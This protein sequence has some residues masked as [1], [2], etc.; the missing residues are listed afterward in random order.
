MRPQHAACATAN[1]GLVQRQERVRYPAEVV[2][3]QDQAIAHTWAPWGVGLLALLVTGWDAG[4]P[5]LW[6]DEVVTLTMAERSWSSMFSVLGRIDAVHGVYYSVIHL[7][8]DVLPYT[9]FILRLPSVILVS[10]TA[11]VLFKMGAKQWNLVAGIVAGL[12]FIGIPR[13]LWM[14]TQARSY[15]LAA[16]TITLAIYLFVVALE[17]NQRRLWV[18]FGAAMALAVWA[19]L[20]NILLVP[21]LVAVALLQRPTSG[22]LRRA[23]I[24]VAAVVAAALPLILVAASQRGQIGWIN[25]TTLKRAL[26]APYYAFFDGT[27]SIMAVAGWVALVVVCGAMLG[28]LTF[29]TP[30]GG[31]EGALSPLAAFTLVLG[32]LALPG[33]VLLTAGAFMSLYYDTYLVISVPALALMIGGGIAA[34]GS[35]KWQAPA[36]LVL[37]AVLAYQPWGFFREPNSKSDIL[38]VIAL[39]ETHARPGDDILFVE[40]GDWNT[41]QLRYAYPDSFQGLRDLT[42]QEDFETSGDFF[43]TSRPLQQVGPELEQVKRLL[44]VANNPERPKSQLANNLQTLTAAGLQIVNEDS[45]GKWRVIVLER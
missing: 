34:A 5:G 21:V 2:R 26:T 32:W 22:H 31:S 39:V 29:R 12:T 18:G 25:H 15:A 38:N 14:S 13:S 23:W 6:Y 37:V 42:L 40:G 11:V 20:Y 44:V 28:W 16:F 1:G 7:W 27:T 3:F 19:F 41:R 8:M 45:T 10:A 43:G 35:K 36:V 30:R 4:V 33:A 9:P 24:A 17:K